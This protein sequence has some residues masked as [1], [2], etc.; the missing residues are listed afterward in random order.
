MNHERP[1]RRLSDEDLEREL[2]EALLMDAP[3]RVSNEL[4]TAVAAVANN[5]PPAK[6]GGRRV[7]A[8]IS[9]VTAIAAALALIA[10]T[11]GV[12]WSLRGGIGAPVATPPPTPPATSPSQ[13]LPTDSPSP[14][15]PAASPSPIATATAAATPPTGLVAYAVIQCVPA[16]V[17]VTTCTSTPRIA[18]SDGS[19][20]RALSASGSGAPMG[21]SAD[22]SRLLLEGD[23]DLIITDATGS[24][25]ATFPIWCPDKPPPADGKC[26]TDPSALCAYPCAG[27]NGFALSPDGT[28]VAFA[29]A[30][31]DVDNAT[32]IAILDLSSGHVTELTATR[33]TNPPLPCNT[34]NRHRTC[35]GNDD[36]PRWSPDGLRIV[37][38][39]QN[40]SPDG[41][42]S[43]DSA[44]LFVVDAD[45]G[46]LRR[47]TPTGLYAFNPSWSPDGTRLAYVNQTDVVN[48]DGTSVVDMKTD[49]YTIGV[50][51]T[52]ATRLT[53]DGASAWPNWTADGRLVLVHLTGG[54]DASGFEHWVMDAD[55][56]NASRLGGSLAELNAA[57]CMT[58]VY[59]ADSFST[60]S[61]Y[62]YWQPVP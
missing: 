22:G 37:F 6:A 20:S 1:V 29:R 61:P 45:G 54:N 14:T 35:Q 31:P 16:S 24:E 53:D 52:G 8:A 10:V 50:D 47:V 11:V 2:K 44:A 59:I 17:H 34:G 60:Q 4:R 62:A 5:Q 43:W 39:R 15:P 7:F 55:G 42:V 27:A 56:G 18:A 57:G 21:W 3:R 41:G 46:N 9:A 30:Y 38:E 58:C 12:L 49:I 13:A 51:G 33:A 32:V 19:D 40:M 36:S 23:A 25:L 48:A 28:R 26:A